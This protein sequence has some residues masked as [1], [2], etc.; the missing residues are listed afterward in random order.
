[1]IVSFEQFIYFQKC[2]AYLQ[3]LHISCDARLFY[4]ADDGDVSGAQANGNRVRQSLYLL[5][6]IE[7]GNRLFRGSCITKYC[8][9]PLQTGEPPNQATDRGIG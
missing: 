6:P 5:H 4:P 1:V 9:L 3:R 8:T 7:T 2:T